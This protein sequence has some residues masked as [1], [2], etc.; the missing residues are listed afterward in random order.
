MVRLRTGLHVGIISNGQVRR[1]LQPEVVRTVF[2]QT[3]RTF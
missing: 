1:D 3:L 2:S